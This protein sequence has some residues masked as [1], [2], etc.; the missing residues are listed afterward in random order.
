MASAAEAG[1]AGAEPD[2]LAVP[3]GPDGAAHAL[4]TLE[5]L[6]TTPSTRQSK[7]LPRSGLAL[8]HTPMTP[9]MFSIWMMSPALRLAGKWPE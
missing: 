5:Q 4:Q 7:G 9:P 8:V 6:S 3:R 1:G 2:L